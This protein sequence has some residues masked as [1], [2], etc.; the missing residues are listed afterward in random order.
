MTRALVLV[1]AAAVCTATPAR[2]QVRLELDAEAGYTVVDIET[3]AEDDGEIAQDWNQ[4]MYRLAARVILGEVSGVT[5]GAE[6]GF[7]YLYWYQVRVPYGDFP[8]S[9]EYDQSGTTALGLIRVTS[10]RTVLDAGAGLA[11][12]GKTRP[13]VSAAVGTEIFPDVS[14]R[15]RAD[16]LLTGALTVPLGVSVSYAF[17]LGGH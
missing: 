12:L 17:S 15:V 10:G 6:L 4:F 8:F 13:M 7:Q 2:S 11:M 14:V 16:A 3:L 1:A 9:R 5:V